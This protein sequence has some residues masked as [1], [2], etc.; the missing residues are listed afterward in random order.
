MYH[1]IKSKKKKRKDAKTH[2]IDWLLTQNLVEKILMNYLPGLHR[3]LPLVSLDTHLPSRSSVGFSFSSETVFIIGRYNKFNRRLSQTPWH[4]NGLR[5]YETSLEEEIVGPLLE[6]FQPREH[7]FHSGG[8]ED[9]DVRMLG[10]GRPFVVELVSPKVR[11]GVTQ[12]ELD[13]LQKRINDTSYLSLSSTRDVKVQVNDL[14]LTDASCFKYLSES[15]KEKVK[16]YSAVVRFEDAVSDSDIEYLSSLE[17]IHL[18]QKTPVRVLHRR[19]LMVRD[20]VI[21]KLKVHRINRNWCVV[22]VLSSAGTYIKE[23]V[24]GDLGRTLPNLGS[25]VGNSADIFQL[26]VLDLY[27]SLEGGTLKEFVEIAKRNTFSFCE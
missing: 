19:T 22:F 24:H 14:A 26:D 6:K 17:E 2:K 20:K 5:L 27:D 21:H 16:A 1:Q 7:K 3:R 8:R 4:V 15:A 9:I 12:E 10:K 25:L 18:K 23:F 11:Y 13:K